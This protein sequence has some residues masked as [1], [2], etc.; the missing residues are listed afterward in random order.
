MKNNNS[1][2]LHTTSLTL[3]YPLISDLLRSLYAEVGFLDPLSLYIA[4]GIL[5]NR[6]FSCPGNTGLE[7]KEVL[8][9]ASWDFVLELSRSVKVLLYCCGFRIEDNLW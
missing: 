9:M 8:G 3:V 7:K 2:Q 4:N 5:S 6:S 1:L